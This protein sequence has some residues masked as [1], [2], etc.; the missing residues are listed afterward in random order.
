M[1]GQGIQ[2]HSPMVL[3]VLLSNI[4]IFSLG[5]FC[6]G[7]LTFFYCVRAFYNVRSF[8]SFNGG[9][10]FWLVM[11]MLRW[12]QNHH[13]PAG[14]YQWLWEGWLAVILVFSLSKRRRAG[15]GRSPEVT[16]EGLVEHAFGKMN[17]DCP[18]DTIKTLVWDTIPWVWI[19][20]PDREGAC[21]SHGSPD[22]G[23]DVPHVQW[24]NAL[25]GCHV[26]V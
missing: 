16:Q 26:F 24:R 6:L 14:G 8:V 13:Y 19:G 3:L 18:Q 22:G 10:T 5:P 7:M 21:Q 12:W 20:H 11:M 9:K 1:S 17:N 2:T 4:L 23:L 15:G 25:W